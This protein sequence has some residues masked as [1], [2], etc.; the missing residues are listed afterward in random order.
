MLQ[1]DIELPEFKEPSPTV[2]G[3]GAYL[4]CWIFIALFLTSPETRQLCLNWQF[5]L[6][7]VAISLPASVFITQT[8]SAFLTLFVYRR[9]TWEPKFQRY[10]KHFHKIDSMSDYLVWKKD[11]GEKEYRQIEREAWEF[12]L[13]MMLG[14]MSILFLISY[15]LYLVFF[16]QNISVFWTGVIGIYALSLCCTTLFLIASKEA[17]EAY[18][19]LDRRAMKELEPLLI[20]WAEQEIKDGRWKV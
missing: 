19:T 6:A 9:K 13:Y 7:L 11:L 5:S 3:P 18:L 2:S 1:G 20:Q 12:N 8:Y 16:S 10:R 14:S 4:I 17:W 15:T